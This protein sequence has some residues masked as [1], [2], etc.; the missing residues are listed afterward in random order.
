MPS[1]A[2]SSG[3]PRFCSS[4]QRANSVLIGSGIS[5]ATRLKPAARLCPA[6]RARLT[7]SRASGNCRAKALN[8]R[9]RL[10]TATQKRQRTG[11]EGD[12]DRATPRCGARST[13]HGGQRQSRQAR[14]RST[15]I[16]P[17]LIRTIGLLEERRAGCR[18]AR[19][20]IST[21][22]TV[23]SSGRASRLTAL[24]FAAPPAGSLR[25]SW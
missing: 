21:K 8:R 23:S 7:S 13:T 6:R 4:K 1:S 5:S 22:P 17:A 20:A 3:M 9:L 2:C 25:R 19:S 16:A 12:A 15:R 18:T 24:A 10:R 11:G 14:R